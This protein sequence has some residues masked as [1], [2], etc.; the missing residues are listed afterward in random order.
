MK[1]LL[2]ILVIS[3]AVIVAVLLFRQVGPVA[4]TADLPAFIPAQTQVLCKA[5]SIANLRDIMKVDAESNTVLGT[6]PLAPAAE[7][8]QETFGI[9]LTDVAAL[10]DA[11][12]DTAGS[13]YFLS[14]NL[15]MT[16]DSSSWGTSPALKGSFSFIAPLKNSGDQA[17]I[18]KTLIDIMREEDADIKVK[19]GILYSG[20]E[21][22]S[23]IF[24][25]VDSLLVI[26][27]GVEGVDP[28][29]EFDLVTAG[30]ESIHATEGYKKMTAEVNPANNIF[31]YANIAE[32][33][34]KENLSE[35][36]NTLSS[37]NSNLSMYS[38]VSGGKLTE[39][40]DF[41]RSTAV[42]ITMNTSDLVA[43]MAVEYNS[44][45]PLSD[46]Y[47]RDYR[48]HGVMNVPMTPAILSNISIDL[49]AYY[50]YIT[51][52]FTEEMQTDMDE[53]IADMST[54][55]GVNIEEGFLQNLGTDIGLAA[56][57]AE[58]ITMGTYNTLLHL[59]IKDGEKLM[60]MLDTLFEAFGQM[61]PPSV[62]LSKD[63]ISGTDCYHA[64]MAGNMA[65][66]YAGVIDEDLVITTEEEIFA[67]L[68]KGK[69]GAAIKKVAH[70][71]AQKTLKDENNGGVVYIDMHQISDFISAM[72]GMVAMGNAKRAEAIT[73]LA[74]E[75]RSINYISSTSELE[76]S[77]MIT[78]SAVVSTN[79]EDTFV[80]GMVKLF[81]R[82]SAQRNA[83]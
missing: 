60:D 65:N 43:N 55:L 77:D 35:I 11:G 80:P 23:F 49:S 6:Y 29:K 7:S 76:G 59:G 24:G 12:V 61:T 54:Q 66:V 45:S 79:F 22:S 8:A 63:E 39:F 56:Y 46:I 68:V 53:S 37:Q 31:M 83:L 74:D 34:L 72:G 20:D 36:L 62:Q 38:D 67:N 21:E 10:A 48:E 26:T 17:E 15:S 4:P 51:S 47:N 44:K 73:N 42:G 70:K 71:D 9:D 75:L 5:G 81:T 40:I 82:I 14:T 3:A 41:Y 58:E 52:A 16:V 18:T 57:D 25:Q 27:I 13:L 28:Q 1:K 2:S 30:T 78:G 19:E 50:D 33:G 64:S 32:T 69:D